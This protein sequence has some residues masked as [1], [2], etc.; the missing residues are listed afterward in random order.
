VHCFR[1]K[2]HAEIIKRAGV[3]AVTKRL[4]VSPNTAWS[5]ARRDS[6]PSPMWIEV[7]EAGWASLDELAAGASRKRPEQAA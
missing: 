2:T 5:W 6:I 4:G 3:D 1:M 7:A